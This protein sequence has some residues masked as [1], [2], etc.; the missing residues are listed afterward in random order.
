MGAL[1]APVVASSY[2]YSAPISEDRS[3]GAKY[4][5]T[6]L[7]A[8]FTRAAKDLTVTDLIGN[9]TSYSTNTAIQAYELRNPNTGAG[10]YVTLHANSSSAADDA[11]QLHVNTSAGQ[12]SIPQHG[13][14]VRLNGHQ[15]KIVVTDFR[16]GSYNLLYSTAEVLT[17]AVFDGEPTLVLWV[18]TGESGEFSIETT[19]LSK[20]K[21]M[22]SNEALLRRCKGC[23]AA[24]FFPG[25]SNQGVTVSFTQDKGMSIVQLN[26]VRVVLL[27]RTSAYNFWAPSLSSDPVAPEDKASEY[28]I[29]IFSIETR[30][31][32]ESQS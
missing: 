25:P 19:N 14:A 28:C 1:A 31:L 23:S 26:S 20:N 30:L 5:E 24:K 6:K 32:T 29:T 27:D 13:G 4:Y 15:S 16:F 8:L 9:G 3:I 12:L 21:T 10:F 17:Y 2:D 7:L 22:A 18:P 11:F